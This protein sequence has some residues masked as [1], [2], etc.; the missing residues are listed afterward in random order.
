MRPSALTAEKVEE[1]ND[2]YFVFSFV[3]NPF[4]R[5]VSCYHDKIARPGQ[6][7]ELVS[8]F[9]FAKRDVNISFDEFLEFLSEEKNL[10]LDAHWAP[11]RDLLPFPLYRYNLIGSVENMSRDLQSLMSR[12]DQH[13]LQVDYRP[14]ATGASR[15]V[16]GIT[17]AQA[18]KISQ[19][20]QGDF[21]LFGYS[22]QLRDAMSPPR[23]SDS[24]I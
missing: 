10:Y 1:I 20:Y 2:N 24:F 7:R 15:K 21:L 18:E 19:I 6:F 5:I 12:V 17:E 11:Q 13:G 14:H 3:R 22:Q 16:T 9:H 23:A 8:R 4:S